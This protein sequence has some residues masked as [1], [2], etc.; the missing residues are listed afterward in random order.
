MIAL[1]QRK[2]GHQVT[3]CAVTR[4]EVRSAIRRRERAKEVSATDAAKALS[5]L[6]RDCGSKFVMQPVNETA[7]HFAA[8]CLDRYPLRA[9]DAIQLGSAMAAR[10][11]IGELVSFVSSD[12]ALLKAAEA[13]GFAVYDPA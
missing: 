2:S 10:S 11:T 6:D 9:Y 8:E 1:A 7:L 12:A 3:I 13:E 5:I 4:V